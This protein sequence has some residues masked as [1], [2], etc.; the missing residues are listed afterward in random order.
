MIE[1]LEAPLWGLPR[2]GWALLV[3]AMLV[4]EIFSWT[5]KTRAQSTLQAIVRFIL[6][7]PVISAVIVRVPIVG[8]ILSYLAGP[9]PEGATGTRAAKPADPPP[10]GAA[11]VLLLAGALGFGVAM[12]GC[13]GLRSVSYKGLTIATDG[14]TGAAEQ[15]PAACEVAELAAA[16]K[17]PTKELK[18]SESGK[19]HA[20]C[21]ATAKALSAT[22]DGLV[23]ARNLVANAPDKASDWA[24]WVLS[25]VQLYQDVRP[26][27]AK[28]GIKLPEVKP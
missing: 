10:S 11:V 21:E 9:D 13:T 23:A 5:K 24:R 7:L 22:H 25:A 8:T 17:Q 26:L 15:L 19:V 28:Y 27:V 1:F 20:D 16:K 6:R 18:I 14:A 3:V 2:W 12:G 4:N